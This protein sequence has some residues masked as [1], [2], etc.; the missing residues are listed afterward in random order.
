MTCSSRVHLPRCTILIVSVA[1]IMLVKD[2][3]AVQPRRTCTRGEECWPSEIDIAELR[4]KLSSPELPRYIAYNSSAIDPGPR[5]CAVPYGS[6]REAPFYGVEWLDAV[7]V[8]DTIHD[9]EKCL[10]SEGES[11]M[12]C[13]AG[14]RNRYA[15]MCLRRDDKAHMR[16]AYVLVY[17]LSLSLLLSLYMYRLL[18]SLSSHYEKREREMLFKLRTHGLING[19]VVVVVDDDDDAVRWIRTAHKLSCSR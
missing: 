5:P 19:V 2:A 10:S 16:Y 11:R 18:H 7:Y 1:L 8:N 14:I 12:I 15:K 4:E 17:S 13:V 3:R 6:P 9:A